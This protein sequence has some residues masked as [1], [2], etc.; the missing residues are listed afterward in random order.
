VFTRTAAA[1]L[2][3]F[4]SRTVQLGNGPVS[5]ILAALLAVYLLVIWRRY[6]PGPL[7]GGVSGAPRNLPETNV[8]YWATMLAISVLGTTL[9]DFVADDMGFWLAQG[10]LLLGALLAMALPAEITVPNSNEMSY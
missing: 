3:D 10:Y 8:R 4:L 5:A 7:N 6:G 9:G 1:D 2:G